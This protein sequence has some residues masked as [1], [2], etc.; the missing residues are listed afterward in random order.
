M[1]RYR[2]VTDPDTP[3]RM[4]TESSVPEEIPHASTL[5]LPELEALLNQHEAQSRDAL[6]SA[7]AKKQESEHLIEQASKA[8]DEAQSFRIR[9]EEAEVTI[10]ELRK[11]IV[12]NNKQTLERQLDSPSR[13]SAKRPSVGIT[14]EDNSNVT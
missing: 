2:S 14:Y 10:Q 7:L 13:A 11:L 3:E 9:Y 4:S 1:P 12:E 6:G 5:A 8:E